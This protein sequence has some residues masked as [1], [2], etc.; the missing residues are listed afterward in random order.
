MKCNNR[1]GHSAKL[2][3]CA[4]GLEGGVEEGFGLF[5]FEIDVMERSRYSIL[6]FEAH[7]FRYQGSLQQP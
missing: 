5:L 7:H 2:E 4:T 1:L 3:Y 6:D